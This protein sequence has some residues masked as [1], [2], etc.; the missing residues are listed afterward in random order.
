MKLDYCWLC[1]FLLVQSL[2]NKVSYYICGKYGKYQ[3]CIYQIENC[4]K[5]E[6]DPENE[7]N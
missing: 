2:N 3:F 7:R 1:G 5:R 4:D 6:F